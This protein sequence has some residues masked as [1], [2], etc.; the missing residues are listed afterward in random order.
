MTC[1]VCCATLLCQGQVKLLLL[2]MCV[3]KENEVFHVAKF[4]C[5]GRYKIE[6]ER[7]GG[8]RE[9]DRE[10]ETEIRRN[11][12][13]ERNTERQAGRDRQTDRQ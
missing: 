5:H 8:E 12:K 7:E 4:I 2:E 11:I 3:L 13:A 6:R 9:R 1:W 10:T